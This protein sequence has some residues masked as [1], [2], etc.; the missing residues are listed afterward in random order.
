M[1]FISNPYPQRYAH[2]EDETLRCGTDAIGAIFSLLRK[3]SLV[4]MNLTN[5]TQTEEFMNILL[6]LLIW[7]IISVSVGVI[8]GMFIKKSDVTAREIYDGKYELENVEHTVLDAKGN[9]R[10]A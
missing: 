4:Q 5:N 6:W 9:K 7:L 8:L 2:L 1:R 10:A 3:P